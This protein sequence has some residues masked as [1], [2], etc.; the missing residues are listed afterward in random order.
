MAQI[1]DVVGIDVSKRTLDVHVL[2]GGHRRTVAN[3]ADGHGELVEWLRSLGVRK[4]VMEAS[5]GYER[6]IGDVLRRA[7]FAVRIVDPRRVRHLAKARGRLAKNDRIDAETIATFGATFATAQRGCEIAA[8]PQ[9]EHLAGLVGA[10]QALV[11]H[12]TGLRNQ[13]AAAPEGE[14][15]QALAAILKP[16]EQAIGKLERLIGDA[17]AKHPPFAAL[18]ARLA[19]V[20]G[21][22]PVAISAILAWLPELG[23]LDRRA[24]AALVGVAP[25][26]D[27][28]G[29]RVGQR[30]IQGGRVKL[31]NVLYMV[32]M[33]AAT[34]HNQVF[35]AYY[36][37][38]IKRGKPAKVAIIA[39]L[40]KLLTILNAMVAQQKDWAPSPAAANAEIAV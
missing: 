26:D 9:R 8:D 22:G 37:A 30:Y 16:I 11:E 1:G 29:Q 35:N 17:I 31:R 14:A 34:R 15:R 4:A 2:A 27:D 38:L 21:L 13:I 19:T 40:R 6:T 18:A 10:R 23:Q 3:A 28:S 33:G 24:L 25:F 36:T 5:G 20:P 39:C 7:G 12:R 32:A